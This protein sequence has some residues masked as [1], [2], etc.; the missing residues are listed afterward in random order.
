MWIPKAYSVA[1]LIMLVS[2]LCWGSWDNTQKIDKKWRFE[3]FYWDCMWGV[4]ACALLFGLILGRTNARRRTIAFF[5]ILPL[6]ARAFWWRRSL[7]GGCFHCGNLLSVAAIS[8]AGMAGDSQAAWWRSQTKFIRSFLIRSG[9]P[10]SVPRTQPLE[11]IDNECTESV[12]GLLPHCDIG[13][14]GARTY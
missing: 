3:L 11:S 4:L 8:F 12:T 14:V 10:G 7:L 6:P 1:V 9:S 13:L 5:T 2:V